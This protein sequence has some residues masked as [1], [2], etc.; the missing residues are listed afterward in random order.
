MKASPW[1][2][3][4]AVDTMGTRADTFVADGVTD[5]APYGLDQP[6]LTVELT[7][8]GEGEPEGFSIGAA[9]PK[10]PF[11]RGEAFYARPLG[12]PSVVT[13]RLPRVDDYIREIRHVRPRRL[14]KDAWDAVTRVTIEGPSGTLAV[15]RPSQERWE[16]SEPHRGLMDLGP[17][18]RAVS[19][20]LQGLESSAMEPSEPGRLSTLGFDKPLG[21]IT[22]EWA[23]G[24]R[25]LLTLGGA[26]EKAAETY[27]TSSEEDL[28][29]TV[30]LQA[31]E[32]LKRNYLE[33]RDPILFTLPIGAIRRLE[34]ERPGESLSF[35]S[36]SKGAWKQSGPSRKEGPLPAVEAWPRRS[37]NSE[38][39][40]GGLA[41]D[42]KAYAEPPA[43]T[44]RIATQDGNDAEKSR[45]WPR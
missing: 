9:L 45:G 18:N 38:P 43:A 27:L 36:P 2:N 26:D 20:P 1:R 13:I 42:W 23:G 39:R 30:P 3:E 40:D 21:R 24:S 32:I 15:E 10:K 31:R 37:R 8:A 16:A 7:P 6:R 44:I 22:V 12:A 4:P 35:E 5:L 33:L 28:L 11:E 14:L 17:F 34:V 19:L 25:Q 41:P 29:F